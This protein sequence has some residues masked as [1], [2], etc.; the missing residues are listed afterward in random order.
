ML[1]MFHF[2]ILT[3]FFMGLGGERHDWMILAKIKLTIFVGVS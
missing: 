1:L 3:F 2:H